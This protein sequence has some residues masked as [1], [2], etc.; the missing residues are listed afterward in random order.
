MW[1]N[2]QDLKKRRRVNEFLRLAY[3]PYKWLIVIPFLFLVTMGLGLIC[4]LV[5][6]IFSRDASDIPAFL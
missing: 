2:S 5:G 6:L 4:I 3:Q 1:T